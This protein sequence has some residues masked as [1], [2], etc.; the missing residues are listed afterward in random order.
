MQRQLIDFMGR[1]F[2]LWLHPDPD[3]LA[4]VI[5]ASRTFYELDVLMK[6]REIYLP[7][8]TIIDV[9]A[10]TGNHTVFFA[11]VL[12]A[13]VHAF[14]PYGPSFDL[15]GISIFTNR[16]QQ[17]VRA[18]FAAVGEQDGKATLTAGPQTNL[19]MTKCALDDGDTPMV[20]L[21]SAEIAGPV[22]LLKIDVEGHEIAV[23]KGAAGLLRD[24]LPDVVIEAGDDAAF[25]AIATHL[26][27]AGYLPRGRFATT[28]TYLFSAQD[29]AA[30][31]RKVLA[32]RSRLR[33]RPDAIVSRTKVAA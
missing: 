33:D 25:H 14:E 2:E 30:R 13:P 22:G 8:T 27:D 10:N 4:A 21:D 11:G 6:C 5:K 12:G 20:R 18:H 19:G 1:R 26:L 32:A 16:L 7:G 17:R 3:H 31:M 24:W 23:L 9:G 28:P 15:L 29:Q